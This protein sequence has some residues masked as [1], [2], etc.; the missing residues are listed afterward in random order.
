MSGESGR[1]KDIIIEYGVLRFVL[2]LLR[3]RSNQQTTKQEWENTLR[4]W[5][6][7]SCVIRERPWVLAHGPV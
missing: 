6:E 7:E 4:R 2:I 3:T 5:R 1:S